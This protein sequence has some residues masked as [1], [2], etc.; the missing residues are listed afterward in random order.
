MDA[1]TEVITILVSVLAAGLADRFRGDDN[2]GIG[3]K[4]ANAIVMGLIVG[5]TILGWD[6][7]KLGI[8]SVAFAGGMAI[9]YGGPWGASLAGRKSIPNSDHWWLRGGLLHD[10][11]SALFVRGILGGLIPVIATK[12]LCDT[13]TIENMRL[14][15]TYI[16]MGLAFPLAPIIARK[17]IDK[18]PEKVKEK[19]HRFNMFT[20][21]KALWNWAEFIRGGSIEIIVYLNCA[22]IT[23]FI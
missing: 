1:I 10:V 20:E 7:P 16:A 3:S 2:L 14:S 6:W 18:V 15:S 19:L 11:D 5:Y 9:S 4:G 21:R 17:T 8:F 12:A 23:F 13:T 22:S